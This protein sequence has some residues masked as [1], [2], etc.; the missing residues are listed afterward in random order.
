MTKLILLL[1]FNDC[2]RAD[3]GWR[4]LWDQIL[5]GFVWLG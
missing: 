5:S 3:P 2:A 4:D 1:R